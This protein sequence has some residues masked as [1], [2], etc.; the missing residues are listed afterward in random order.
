MVAVTVEYATMLRTYRRRVFLPKSWGA[1][2]RLKRACNLVTR[3][4]HPTKVEILDA[5][6]V[7]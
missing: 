3:Q 7:I 1:T 5:W 4:L 2:K 6:T